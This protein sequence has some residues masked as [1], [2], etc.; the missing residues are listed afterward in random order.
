[1]VSYFTYIGRLL[2]HLDGP[3]S[4]RNRGPHPALAELKDDIVAHLGRVDVH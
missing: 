1:M 4:R 2:Y 3:F